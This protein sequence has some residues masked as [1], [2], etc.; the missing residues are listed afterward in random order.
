MKFKLIQDNEPRFSK[1]PTMKPGSSK[2]GRF[3]K[4]L[5]K[6]TQIVRKLIDEF[7]SVYFRRR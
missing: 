6:W 4:V 1:I 7:G 2:S 3:A 5:N